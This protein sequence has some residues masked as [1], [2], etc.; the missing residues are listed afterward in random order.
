V[1]AFKSEP[2]SEFNRDFLNLKLTFTD[3]FGVAGV[4]KRVHNHDEEQEY[5]VDSVGHAHRQVVVVGAQLSVVE[6]HY[7]EDDREA[8]QKQGNEGQ[9][10]H[11]L[12]RG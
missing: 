7:S 6:A 12:Q 2:K 8:H 5:A 9:N 3:E 11:K 10:G 1:P 4:D